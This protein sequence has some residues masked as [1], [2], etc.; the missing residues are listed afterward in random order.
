VEGVLTKRIASEI[1][2]ALLVTRSQLGDRVALEALIRR[3]SPPLQR[4]LGRLQPDGAEDLFQEAWIRVFRGLGGVKDP[5]AFRA[6]LFGIARHLVLDGLRRRYATPT[7]VEIAGGVED[8]APAEIEL[9][10]LE[11][12]LSGLPFI[13]RETLTLFYI[14]DLSLAQVAGVQGV[15]IGTVKSRL[16]RARALLAASMRGTR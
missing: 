3:W 14:E 6:W 4:H 13:E 7:P 5:Y 11:A 16:H 12:C 1:A 10:M 2:D 15:P 9:Q 8:D